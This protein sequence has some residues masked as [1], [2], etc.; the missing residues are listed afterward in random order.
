MEK[1][2][3]IGAAGIIRKDNKILIAQRKKDSWMEPNKWEFPGGKVE[4]NETFEDCLI[5]E[6]YEELGIIISIERLFMKTSH[7]YMKG[8]EEFPVTLMV[9]LADWKEGTIQNID[10]QDSKWVDTRD[11]RKFDFA[12]ADIAIIDKLLNSVTKKS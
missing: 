7:V 3:N 2:Q 4:P 6:I 1:K 8:V 12:A 10:C 9:F 11:L 5:R